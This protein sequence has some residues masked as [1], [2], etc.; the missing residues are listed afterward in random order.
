M[1][2]KFIEKLSS[3]RRVADSARTTIGLKEGEKEPSD[4][5][6]KK[7]LLAEHS[8]IRKLQ[9]SWKWDDIKSWVSVHFTRHWL[10]IVHFVSTQR[11][12]RTKGS[13]DRNAARQDALISH[14]ATANAQALIYIS[15]KRLCSQASKETREAWQSAK[16]EIEG[17]EPILASTMV[18]ECL[19]RGFCPELKPCGYSDTEAFQEKLTEYRNKEI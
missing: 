10:G 9:Y 6:K 3:W 19:Y 13:I 12:D 17:H 5:W 16:D 2:V 7:M 1:K 4:S 15:R 8:P 14:E 11:N 18:C